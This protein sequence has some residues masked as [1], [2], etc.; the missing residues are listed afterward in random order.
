MEKEHATLSQLSYKSLF[1]VLPGS[2]LVLSPDYII[3]EASEHY[4]K[5]TQK[6]DSAI[7]GR[8][9]LEVIFENPA[10]GHAKSREVLLHSLQ[11]VVTH[12]TAHTID[13]I[14]HDVQTASGTLEERYWTFSNVPV[15]GA[16]KEIAYI[17]HEVR[18]ITESIK[19]DQ[20]AATAQHKLWLMT[21]ATGGTVWEIDLLQ[22]K[23]KWSESYKTVFGYA[24]K[25]LETD[26]D[27]RNQHILPEDLPEVLAAL[28]AVITNKQKVWSLKYRYRKADGTYTQVIDYGCVI[29]NDQQDKP[30]R[31]IGSIVD[32]G[33]QQEYEKELLEINQRF[34]RIAMATN[35]VI[36]DWN[37]KDDSIWWNEGFKTLF[38][39]AEEEIEDTAISW[40]NRIH[41]D[42]LQRVKSSIHQVID[43]G[44]TNWEDEYRFRC[45]DGTYKLVHDRGYVIHDQQHTAKR[46]IG[47]M[48]DITEKRRIE[49]QLKESTA[50]TKQILES[51]PLM[52][53]TA[54]PSGDLNYYSQRW[55][56]YT[57][58]NFE[59]MQAWGWNKY[60]HADDIENTT[61]LWLKSIGTGEPLLLENRFRSADGAYRWFL[62]RALP[63]RD[64][65]GNITQW[66]G[67]HTDIEDHKQMLLALEDSNNKFRFLTESIP[68]LVW[69]A[70]PDGVQDYYNQRWYDYTGITKQHAVH[71]NWADLLHPD[72]R[73]RV[74]SR[75]EHSVKTGEYYE[76]EYRIQNTT[77]G[78]FR[79]F[80]VQAVPM[81]DDQDCITKWFGTCTDIEDHKLAEEELV[82]KIWSWSALTRIWIAL[83]T[84]HRMT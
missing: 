29:C 52:T 40:T 42:D 45:A 18:D 64:S 31:M 33:S 5:T 2:F 80:L 26:L 19:K 59:Q 24:D 68:Q 13:V 6:A 15:L 66:V 83:Y 79:W 49:Q 20:A 63:I 74:T 75:W 14:R 35:D 8:P 67:S 46:M 62:V 9:L 71:F 73:A 11:H 38:G 47:A 41:P 60:I 22:Q 10:S 34:Q 78:S 48:L 58:S 36:W 21:E 4:L 50:Q 44:E 84:P 51:L 55:Y 1:R 69:T 53:W 12:K 39:Y 3:V 61:E 30:S 23:I 57:G 65:Q 76:A 7:I 54:L 25:D 82:E 17:L 32:A 77:S 43:S 16:Q 27:K 72:D 70:T 56:D 37:L 28:D 81:R